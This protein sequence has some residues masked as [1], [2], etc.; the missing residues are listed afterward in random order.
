MAFSTL[1]DWTQNTEPGIRHYSGT[2]I[3]R[4]SFVWKGAL[5]D[6]GLFIDL[7]EVKELA[8]VKLNGHPLGILWAKPFRIAIPAGILREGENQLVVEVVNFWPN[9]IIGDADLPQEKRLTTTNVRKLT[10][11]TPLMPS[12]L[13]GPVR[14]VRTAE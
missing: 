2:A 7:G 9:R 5:P 6:D 14:I 10:A 13:L 12:G 3:Y 8:E 11:A 1:A 4:K